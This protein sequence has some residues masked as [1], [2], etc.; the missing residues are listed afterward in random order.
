MLDDERYCDDGAVYDVNA[1][2]ETAEAYF[3]ALLL[4]VEV[5][6]HRKRMIGGSWVL[7]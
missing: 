1:D 4:E 3:T 7:V 6:A 2:Y 5:P